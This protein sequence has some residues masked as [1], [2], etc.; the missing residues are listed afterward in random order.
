[1]EN[2][3]GLF[4]TGNLQNYAALELPLGFEH[5]PLSGL[6][7]TF[8]GWDDIGLARIH[9]TTYENATRPGGS[10]GDSAFQVGAA[11]AHAA[12]GEEMRRRAQA[13]TEQPMYSP[14]SLGDAIIPGIELP[15]GMDLL[16]MNTLNPD[17]SRFKD[18]DLVEI[19]QITFENAT[20]PGE[21]LSADEFRANAGVRHALIG[22]ELTRRGVDLPVI[23]TSRWQG[24]TN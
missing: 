18:R 6:T 3:C 24:Y 9:R 20:S 7:R 2:Y 21:G 14:N 17:F 19:Y 4:P 12:I 11:L 23:D 22:V 1:M 15:P 13:H 8:E 5:I 16:W 10:N